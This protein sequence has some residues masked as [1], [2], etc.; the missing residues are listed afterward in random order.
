M[1]TVRAPAVLLA[2]MNLAAMAC[3]PRVFFRRGR[4]NAAWWATAAPF[5]LSGAVLIGWWVRALSGAGTVD[6]AVGWAWLA[7]PSVVVAG[8]SLALIGWTAGTHV[9]PVS[10]WHQEA[11][12]PVGIVTRGP[13]RWVR[14]PFYLAFIGTLGAAF[15]AAPHWLTGVALALGSWRLRHTAIR[16][17]HRI[18][19]SVHGPGYRRYMRRTGRFLPRPGS[20]GTQ[21]FHRVQAPDAT[22]R[23]QCSQECAQEERAP[24]HPQREGIRTSDPPEHPLQHA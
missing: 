10:L 9:H 24:N 7:L 1:D 2:L 14:H 15:L 12:L 3:L 8:G 17:E 13:Y 19:G 21:G 22:A 6:A 5:G 11:D 20:L 4:L 23:A 16:E 18:L